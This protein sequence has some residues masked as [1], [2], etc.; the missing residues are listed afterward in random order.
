MS[1]E[2]PASR[3]G[4]LADD[5]SGAKSLLEQ[6]L[7]APVN[8]FQY[9]YSAAGPEVE[10]VVRRAGFWF[11]RTAGERYNLPASFNPFRLTSFAIYRETL[12][13]LRE[14]ART[15]S[16]GRGQWTILLYHH[17][18]DPDSREMQTML[19]H[20]VEHTYSVTPRT[21]GRQIRLARNTGAWVAPLEDVG[22]Y[23]LLHRT[24]RLDLRQSA[25]VV[26]LG[27][28][29]AE[30]SGLPPVPMTVLLDVPWQ[31]VTV[32]GSESDGTYSPYGGRLLLDVMPG[33]EVTV[34]QTAEPEPE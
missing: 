3:P 10:A 8:V 15:V 34:S 19:R 26:Q 4:Q 31:W 17:V 23:L 5:V 9:P 25:R 13:N 18:L 1:H 30:A 24:A 11:A 2:A 29:G 33:E 28:K 16:R 12:P 6:K 27:I 21:Y 22:R 32:S 20:N 14:F 7:G